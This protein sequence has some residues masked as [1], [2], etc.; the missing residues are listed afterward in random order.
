MGRKRGHGEGTIYQRAD[1]RWMARV[2]TGKDPETGKP[3]R[4]TVYGAT[5]G[6][7]QE[8]LDKL[9]DR[10]GKGIVRP[11]WG[12][13]WCRPAWPRPSACPAPSVRR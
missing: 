12:C 5:R 4:E 2:M 10:V 1:G 8:K 11:P 9:R 13:R 3:I 6:E 7:C